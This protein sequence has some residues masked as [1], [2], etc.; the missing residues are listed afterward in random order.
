MQEDSIWSF[1]SHFNGF[2][3]LLLP[4]TIPSLKDWAWPVRHFVRHLQ[5]FYKMNKSSSWN[6]FA[7]SRGFAYAFMRRSTQ[8]VMF[9]H[10][11]RGLGR[12][13]NKHFAFVYTKALLAEACSW[14]RCDGIFWKNFSFLLYI[15][16]AS[17]V[18]GYP[19]P[20]TTCWGVPQSPICAKYFAATHSM[21]AILNHLKYLKE[22]I[23]LW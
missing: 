16:W 13:P 23:L 6:T 11:S 14:K 1:I 9:H 10:S 21:N 19:L 4:G 3:T 7:F 2:D 22:L 12:Y 5:S 18:R 20:R 15:K 17:N 8:P